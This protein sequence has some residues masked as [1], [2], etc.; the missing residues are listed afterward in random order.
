MDNLEKFFTCI[1]ELKVYEYGIEVF[2]NLLKKIGQNQTESVVLI[3]QI[4]NYYGVCCYETKD[5]QSGIEVFN[6][7]RKLI[8]SFTSYN[9]EQNHN[10]ISLQMSQFFS[11]LTRGLPKNWEATEDIYI[12]LWNTEIFFIFYYLVKCRLGL[13]EFWNY[14][15]PPKQLIYNYINVNNLIFNIRDKSINQKSDETYYRFLYILYQKALAKTK[16][17]PT[18][19]PMLY[20][21]EST[22]YSDLKTIFGKFHSSPTLTLNCIYLDV[23]DK[24]RSA[25]S[26]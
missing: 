25:A 11:Y 23:I 15:Y 1:Q 12:R 20:D 8:E 22:P 17:E 26:V 6:K 16:Y 10:E 9:L 3:Y 19:N 5:F 24:F 7:S 4:S 13:L 18:L 14:I 21:D 2:G